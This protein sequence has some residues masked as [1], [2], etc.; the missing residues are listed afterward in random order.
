L[1]QNMSKEEEDFWRTA[2]LKESKKKNEKRLAGKKETA[3]A[4][5]IETGT[6]KK[7]D[8]AQRPQ[9]GRTKGG[10]ARSEGERPAGTGRGNAVLRQ[11]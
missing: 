5:I 1:A 7:R 6:L 8:P 2:E 9:L 3:N 10:R 4:K 11:D